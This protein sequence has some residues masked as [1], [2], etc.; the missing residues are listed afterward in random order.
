MLVLKRY[1][2]LGNVHRT[3]PC[4]EYPG[5][6]MLC[7]PKALEEK[8]REY[9]RESHASQKEARD[10]GDRLLAW[11]EYNRIEYNPREITVCWKCSDE[12]PRIGQTWFTPFYRHGNWTFFGGYKD[13]FEQLPQ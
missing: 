13:C 3:E 7:I 1:A 9:Y 4:M 5:E 6:W 12:D 2:D 8:S 11:L 10:C